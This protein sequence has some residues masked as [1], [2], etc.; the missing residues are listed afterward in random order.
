MTFV[1]G[2][3]TFFAILAVLI[4]VHEFGHF[5]T[6]KLFQVRVQEFGLGFPPRLKS[7][8]RGET[9]YSINLIPLGGFVKM[10]GE[11]GE[12]DD[13][14]S[15]GAHPQWQRFAVLA[16]GP[17][18]NLLLAFTIFYFVFLVGAPRIST[19]VVRVAA[20]GPAAE[21]GIRTGDR[22]TAIN[23]TAVRYIEGLQASEAADAGRRVTIKYLH[24]GVVH[25]T[26]VLVRRHPPA[27][28]GPLGIVL[29]KTVIVSNGPT[30]SFRMAAG[31]LGTMA[32]S[33]PLLIQSISQHGS[34]EVSGPIGIAHLTT[35]VV[36]SEP[37]TGPGSVLQ[38]MALLSANLGV[39]NLLP[40]PAL[41]GGRL[42]F[43]IVS[44]IRRRNLDPQ[45]EGMIHLVGMAV[46]LFLILVISY[47]DLARWLS[48]SPY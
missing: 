31:E 38:F 9:V 25:Q 11:N 23:G 22:I 33:V 3:L 41:D 43:V 10:L 24:D 14:G 5:A 46:L 2:I 48:G 16:A 36:G 45:V 8:Q 4:L 13:P 21:A 12:T 18:M 35:Q 19:I 7:W 27:N 44:W 28:Q 42:V 17:A 15:F 1:L 29:G 40:I 37:S 34:T 32:A 47:Q 26:R 39:L 6:A 30:T 20:H